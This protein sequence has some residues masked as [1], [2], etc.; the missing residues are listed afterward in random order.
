MDVEEEFNK[1]LADR[2]AK[3]NETVHNFSQFTDTDGTVYTTESLK[4]LL[5]QEE[6]AQIYADNSLDVELYEY[7]KSVIDQRQSKFLV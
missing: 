4:A 6:I 2:M 7:A 1:I 5:T 3:R